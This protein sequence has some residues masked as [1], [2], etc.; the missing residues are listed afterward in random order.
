MC[1]ELLDSTNLQVFFH[2]L[3][4]P[5]ILKQTCLKDGESVLEHNAQNQSNYR[6][7]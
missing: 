4:T 7:V 5:Q 6:Y 2:K 1:N 3:P